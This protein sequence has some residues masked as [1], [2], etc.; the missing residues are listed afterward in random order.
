MPLFYRPSETE[1]KILF[2]HIPK[3]GGTTIEHFFRD[4]GMFRQEPQYL[5]TPWDRFVKRSL[6][7]QSRCSLQ[8][9]TFRETI[10]ISPPTFWETIDRVFVIFRNPYDRL[11]SEYWYL[12]KKVFVRPLDYEIWGLDPE[13]VQRGLSDFD[14]FIQFAKDGYDRDSSF[15]DNHFIPQMEFLQGMEQDKILQKFFFRF[16]DLAT[17]TLFQDLVH[18]LDL[19]VPLS[20]LSSLSSSKKPKPKN[21]HTP[22]NDTTRWSKATEDTIRAWY[23]IDFESFGYPMNNDHVVDVVDA[24][25]ERGV[26]RLQKAE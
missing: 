1:K 15:L 20:S 17:G 16:E 11:L 9:L 10:K 24:E 22:V 4:H 13:T 26:A 5:Y 3:N 7:N 2:L 19:K 14:S 6:A 8:H 18:S 21:K 25:T 12:K 23:K